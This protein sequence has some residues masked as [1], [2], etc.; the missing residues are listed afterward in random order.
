MKRILPVIMILMCSIASAWSADTLESVIEQ[1]KKGKFEI[2]KQCE[3][4]KQAAL[5]SYGTWLTTMMTNLQKEGDLD[6]YLALRDEKKRFDAEHTVPGDDGGNASLVKVRT[7]YAQAVQKAEDERIS[8]TVALLKQSMG[9]MESLTRDLVKAGNIDAAQKAREAEE[10]YR[11]ELAGMGV[12][13]AASPPAQQSAKAPDHKGASAPSPEAAVAVAKIPEDA[14]GL[15]ESCYKVFFEKVTWQEAVA[16]CNALGGHLAVISS[17]AE[18]NMVAALV[19]QQPAWLGC[20]NSVAISENEEGER[21]W[22]I[23]WTWVNG[24]KMRFA[25][26]RWEEAP[27]WARRQSYL[28]I[29]EDPRNR[30]G[31]GTDENK[32]NYVCEWKAPPKPAKTA[33]IGR[34]L[35]SSMPK[36]SIPESAV[37]YNGHSYA[38]FQGRMSWE[39]AKKECRKVGGHLVSINGEIENRVVTGLIGDRNAWIGLERT[40]KWRWVD[41]GTADEY[42]NWSA[43]EPDGRHRDREGKREIEDKAA[44]IG[45]RMGERRGKWSDHFDNED[46]APRDMII[47]QYVCEWDQ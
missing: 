18:N 32:L 42:S 14:V 27:K 20:S 8:R 2:N 13:E 21:D 39:Q 25:N 47:D 10:A 34:P 44:I 22:K 9:R 3:S 12:A 6:G 4:Q 17:E 33:T 5:G 35:M 37:L 28:T 36:L 23:S 15:K 31:L 7:A 16:R 46:V 26:W 1:I 24:E 43:G 11:K 29:G 45:A 40:S 19:G 38:V 30:W 41:G